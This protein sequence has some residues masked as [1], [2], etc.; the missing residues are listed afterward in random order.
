MYDHHHLFFN[1]FLSL[2]ALPRLI[3]LFYAD[4]AKTETPAR[5]AQADFW[6]TPIHVH[7]KDFYANFFAA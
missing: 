2:T 1:R 5:K 6:F 3:Y 4:E 7:I